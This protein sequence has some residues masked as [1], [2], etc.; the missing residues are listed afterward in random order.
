MTDDT[1]TTR[2]YPTGELI[3]IEPF[4]SCIAFFEKLK[5]L[6]V[7]HDRDGIMTDDTTSTRRG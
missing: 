5:A 4:R 2:G 1:T 6:R 3:S 7:S